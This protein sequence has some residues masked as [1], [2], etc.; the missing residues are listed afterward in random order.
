MSEHESR[1]LPY[2]V[3]GSGDHGIIAVHGWFADRGAFR[4]V[5][6]YLDTQRFSYVFVDARGYG[7]ATG[8]VGDYTIDE[9][10][11]DVLATADALGWREFSLLGHSMGGKVAQAVVARAGERVRSVV[12]VSPVP[13]GGVPFDAEP[14][15][16]FYGA[17]DDRGNRRAILD[18]TT[19]NR[20]TGVWLDAMSDYSVK[21]CDVEAFRGY[22]RSWAGEDF[23]ERVEGNPVPIL[24]F[25]G[26][27]DPAISED[28]VR[29]TFGQWFPNVEIRVL[30]GVGHYAPDESPIALVSGVE[31]F[32]SR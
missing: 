27:H 18:L 23:H 31:E 10:A 22:L 26:E 17:P 28:T 16:L 15:R 3:H 13:A 6:P 1:V 29:A 8:V 20:L 7:G 2:E 14:E 32:L 21:R 12:G 30:R 24:V 5:L 9:V 25:V 11:G 4:S 19:G